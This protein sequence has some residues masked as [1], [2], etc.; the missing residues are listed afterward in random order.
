MEII[1]YSWANISQSKSLV[2]VGS[3]S[4]TWDEKEKWLE[5]KRYVPKKW[6]P[7]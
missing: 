5:G 4:D 7:G 1:S 2:T 3:K 6:F